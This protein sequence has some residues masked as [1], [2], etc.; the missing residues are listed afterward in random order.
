MTFRTLAAGDWPPGRVTQSWVPDG[1]RREAAV[2]AAIDAAWATA[3]ARPDVRLFDG[4]MCRLERWHVTPGRLHLDL[5]P[6][7]YKPF[8]GTNMLNPALADRFGPD[9]MANPVGV[10]TV[11]ATADGLLML[12]RRN[13][14]VAY[15]PGRI[16]PFA[17]CLEPGDADV[18]AAVRRELSEELSLSPADVPDLRC[19]AVV[20]DLALRQPELLFVATTVA[21]AADVAARLDADEH[22]DVWTVTAHVDQVAESLSVNAAA[23]TPVATAVLS[24]WA[25]WNDHRRP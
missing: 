5:S 6:T 12:G 11:L 20:E 14:S 4:P 25:D 15:Y 21:S 10:S 19:L 8:V 3:A 18:F 23:R 16:H 17:G 24:R 1:R 13:Q 9:V 7:S 22:V 2:D